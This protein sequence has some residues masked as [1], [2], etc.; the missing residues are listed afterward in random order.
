[1]SNLQFKP[2]EVL[3]KYNE[4]IEGEKKKKF[5]LGARGTYNTD[6]D[7]QMERI[8]AELRAQSVGIPHVCFIC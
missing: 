4:E 7:K 5:E 2:K 8:K 3:S 1:M 6:E